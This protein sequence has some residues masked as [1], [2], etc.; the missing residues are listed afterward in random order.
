MAS[1]GKG[2][3]ASFIDAN[4]REISKPAV[5]EEAKEKSPKA[6]YGMALFSAAASK[7]EN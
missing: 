3:K 6:I 7:T 5:I 2:P 1:E 4:Y